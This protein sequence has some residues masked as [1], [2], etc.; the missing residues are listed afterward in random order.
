[1][2]PKK[3]ETQEKWNF[4]AQNAPQILSESKNAKYYI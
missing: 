2:K 4:S 3:N 1:M